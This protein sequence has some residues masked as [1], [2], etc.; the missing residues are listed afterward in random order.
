MAAQPLRFSTDIKR[1]VVRD[2]LTGTEYVCD[3]TMQMMLLRGQLERAHMTLPATS[4][5]KARR[6]QDIAEREQAGMYQ[7]RQ[8]VKEDW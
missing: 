5:R 6:L 2:T 1:L 4:E 8:R 7:R 3:S